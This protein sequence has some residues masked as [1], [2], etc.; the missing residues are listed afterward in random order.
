MADIVSL[1]AKRAAQLKLWQE[2]AERIAQ[3]IDPAA[4]GFFRRCLER[5]AIK[6]MESETSDGPTVPRPNCRS[7]EAK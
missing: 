3:E 1:D 6:G 7:P 2:R 5:A 4:G